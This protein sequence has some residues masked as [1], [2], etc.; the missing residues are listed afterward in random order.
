MRRFIAVVKVLLLVLTLILFS[1]VSRADAGAVIS[2]EQAKSLVSEQSK[3]LR[4]LDLSRSQAELALAITKS[5]FG[6]GSYYDSSDMKKDIDH[7]EALIEERQ[8]AIRVLESSIEQWKEQKEDPE[9]DAAELERQIS[10]AYQEIADYRDMIDTLRPA[11]V[12]LVLRYHPAKAQ[13]DAVKPQLEPYEKA[14]DQLS[15]A[16]VVQPKLMDYSVEQLYLSLL[17]FG[18]QEETLAKAVHLAK[19]GLEIEE[20]KLRLG[21]STVMQ[22]NSAKEQLLQREDALQGLK[23][24]IEEASRNFLYMAGLPSNFKFQLEPVNLDTKYGIE[25]DGTIPDFTNSLSYRRAFNNLHD[26]EEE[27]EDA[28]EFNRNEYRLAEV[29]VQEAE[30]Q[31]QKTLFALEKNFFSRKEKFYSAVS[32][33]ETAALSLEQAKS[34]F[35]TAALQL[36][37]GIIAP[38]AL[39]QAEFALLQAKFAHYSAQMQKRFAF[40]AYLLALEGIEIQLY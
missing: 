12:S 37:L 20:L 16:Q 13:E 32:A 4:L 22:V 38:L 8:N 18:Q 14:L 34:R 5:K 6:I 39:D 35:K 2:L 1:H 40:S 19:R 21:M 3:D 31:L 11:H 33:E 24:E 7:L 27:L 9:A 25:S 30:I 29:N 17:A 10:E 15:D 26:A 36:E 28:S 23:A